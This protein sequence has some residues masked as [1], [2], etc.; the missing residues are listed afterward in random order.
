MT[1][2]KQQL[3]GDLKELYEKAAPDVKRKLLKNLSKPQLVIR[4]R[5]RK[6]SPNF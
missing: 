5:S 1:A 2:A 3:A 4:Q 6:R